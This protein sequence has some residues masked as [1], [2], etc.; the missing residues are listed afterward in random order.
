MSLSFVDFIKILGKGKNGSRSL[1]QEEAYNAMSMILA[2]QVAPEQLGAFW[3]LIRM[4]EE[5]VDEAVG[6]TQAIRQKLSLQVPSTVDVDWPAYA[7]KRN[8]LPWFLLAALALAQS[9][10]KVFMHGHAFAEEERIYVDQ[11]IS[12]LGLPIATDQAAAKQQLAQTGFA[13]MPLHTMSPKLAQLMDLK[14]LLGLR[15]PVNTLVRLMNPAAATH[16]VHGVFHKGYDELHMAAAKR[17][18][19]ESVLVF[20]GGNGE[21]EVNPE[22]DVT[23]GFL[24]Q[25]NVSWDTWP[26]VALGHCRQK[27]NLDP[28]RLLQHWRNATTDVFG[29]LAVLQT[30]ASVIGLMNPSYDRETCQQEATRVW[31]QRDTQCFTKNLGEVFHTPYSVAKILSAV[32]SSLVA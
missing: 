8:E 21:A 26:K 31:Q 5:T 25:G 18:G 30:L 27:N 15:S 32:N 23:L 2:E 13:Y 29:E 1:T 24:Q 22:R 12:W 28:Q 9:G 19:D 11:M 3:M 20:R 14:L 17:L 6:F 4:R 10:V 16:S 7:G